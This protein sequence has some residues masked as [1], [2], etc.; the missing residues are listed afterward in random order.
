MDISTSDSVNDKQKARQG[1]FVCKEPK[2][3]RLKE[4]AESI[5]E[6]FGKGMKQECLSALGISASS[7]SADPV[8]SAAAG[9]KQEVKE[10]GAEIRD[11]SNYPHDKDIDSCHL[12]GAFEKLVN[13][14]RVTSPNGS[15]LWDVVYRRVHRHCKRYRRTKWKSG[16]LDDK[17]FKIVNEE[18]V[19][20]F[21]DFCKATSDQTMR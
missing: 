2:I 1:K 4:E 6:Q 14:H 7:L 5:N 12:V 8:L 16:G 19:G 9:L 15:G 13:E 10:E 17:G 21:L 18:E 11:V 20:L 3:K